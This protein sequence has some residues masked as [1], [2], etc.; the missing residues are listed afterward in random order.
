MAVAVVP[1]VK[2]GAV[3]STVKLLPVFAMAG[4]PAASLTLAVS[5]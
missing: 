4:L 1:E 5:V 2:L 3:R